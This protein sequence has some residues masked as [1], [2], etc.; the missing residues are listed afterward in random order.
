MQQTPLAAHTCRQTKKS[1][2]PR[3]YYY[4]YYYRM[5]PQTGRYN[6]HPSLQRS[7]T[8]HTSRQKGRLPQLAAVIRRP[9]PSHRIPDVLQEEYYYLL[10]YAPNCRRNYG[11]M[12]PETGRGGAE[13]NVGKF[14][15]LRK[16]TRRNIIQQQY[17]SYDT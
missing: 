15:P 11:R 17:I 4:Y 5:Q 14:A 9:H 7:T 12:E 1:G 16:V 3:C 2:N 13:G 6:N 8:H 10:L